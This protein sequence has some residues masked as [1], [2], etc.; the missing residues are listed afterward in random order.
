M[1]KKQTS[2]LEYLIILLFFVVLTIVDSVSAFLYEY[3][4]QQFVIINRKMAKIF[5][6]I[7]C[8]TIVLILIAQTALSID[9]TEAFRFIFY[10]VHSIV[11]TF[12]AGTSALVRCFNV[13]ID[14]KTTMEM[15][16]FAALNIFMII[17]SYAHWP[18]V[19]NSNRKYN[20]SQ[21]DIQQKIIIDDETEET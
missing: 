9:E 16:E 17:M 11:M 7:A 3:D 2:S 15:M 10:F 13:S 1:Q 19:M 8:D 18:C 20:T 5:V 12:V 14:I 6:E 4:L 21:E